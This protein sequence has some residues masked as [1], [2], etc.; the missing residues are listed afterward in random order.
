MLVLNNSGNMVM[1][2]D[3][4]SV[5]WF[6][7]QNEFLADALESF[8]SSNASFLLMQAKNYSL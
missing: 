4:H 3:F 8:F 5:N 2:S 1:V 7:N 6:S